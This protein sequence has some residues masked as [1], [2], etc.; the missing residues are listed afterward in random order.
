MNASSITPAT[1]LV[2]GNGVCVSCLRSNREIE[3]GDIR[4]AS[5]G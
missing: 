1:H 4:A 5:D 2:Y 3:P